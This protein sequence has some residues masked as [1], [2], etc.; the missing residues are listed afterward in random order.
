MNIQLN[1]KFP[2]KIAFLIRHLKRF[3]L[4]KETNRIFGKLSGIQVIY[5]INLDRQPDRWRQILK[6]AKRQKVAGKGTLVDFFYRISAIDGKDLCNNAIPIK[7]IEKTFTIQDQYYVD[8]DPQ[9]L[10]AIRNRDIFIDMS[11]EEIAVALSHVTSWQKIIDEERSYALILED[12]IF[13]ESAFARGLNLLW[14]ELPG[15]GASLPNFDLLYLSYREVDRGAEK[16]EFSK[17]LMRPVKGLWWLS[18]YVLSNA[19]AKKLLSLLPIKGPVGLWINLQF[20]KLDVYASINSLIY[21]RDDLKSN[22]KYSILPILS[23]I[24]IQSDKT[25]LDLQQRKGRNPAFVF[26]EN[27]SHAVVVETALSLLGYTCCVDRWGHFSD[28]IQSLIDAREPLLFDAYIGVKALSK[29]YK[30]LDLMYPGAVFILLME[31]DLRFSKYEGQASKKLTTRWPPVHMINHTPIN[32]P[33]FLE[34]FRSKRHKLLL[35][36]LEKANNWNTLCNFLNCKTPPCDFP[37]TSTIT[38]V[39]AYEIIPL[40]QKLICIQNATQ[41][42]HDVTPWIIPIERIS[43][44]GI[45]SLAPKSGEQVGHFEP[46]FRDD[47]VNFNEDKWI[48]LENSFPSNLADFIKENFK[49]CKPTGFSLT[50]EKRKTKSRNY[51]SASIASRKPYVYGRFEVVM[52]PV[53]LDGVITAFFLHRNDPWQELDFE[54]L[55]KDTSKVLFNVYFNPG[56]N[57]FGWNFGNRGTPILVDLGFDAA[58]D[59]HKYA[60]EW[61][62]HEIRWFVDDKLIHIRATWEPTPI[63]NLPMK[64]YINL[65]PSLSEELAGTFINESLP[66]NAYVKS[67]RIDSWSIKSAANE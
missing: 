45:S 18:G 66:I 54:F 26:V 16:V 22:N 11:Q 21:Q 58:A 60:I 30:E 67:V 4:N 41:L 6:E 8:P 31:S 57:E 10:N 15:D 17:H 46:I 40:S 42:Q 37:K 47:F 12:D 52:R 55:G 65:W 25:H 24:G 36:N 14:K 35:M 3:F 39:A 28:K 20:K 53:K 29:N 48:I 33:E 32:Y 38:E 19:G 51:S 43:A 56:I 27:T 13:F 59:Y 34:Y 2:R 9:L 63:P 5:V 64:F 61:E 50:L 49:L 62:P 44:F 7:Q 1:N 23:Q